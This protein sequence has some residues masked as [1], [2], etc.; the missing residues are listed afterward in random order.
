MESP[1]SEPGTLNPYAM[2]AMAEIGIDISKH[3][4]KGLVAVDLAGADVIVTLCADEI[5]PVEQAAD[6]VRD[7]VQ[8]HRHQL[9][10]RIPQD[11]EMVGD[12]VRLVQ[13]MTNLLPTCCHG[14]STPSSRVPAV[15]EPA[16]GW[17]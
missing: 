3:Q 2:A 6:A 5:C 12:C 16:S 13:I 17:G 1:G 14:F 4:P 10:L 15:I 9:Q 11:L 7:S 8:R